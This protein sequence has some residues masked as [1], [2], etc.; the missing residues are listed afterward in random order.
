MLGA[1]ISAQEL[2][3]TA[4]VV[5]KLKVNVIVPFGASVCV[6]KGVIFWKVAP[7]GPP[8]TKE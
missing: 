8:D 5:V 6:A 7:V 2:L 3:L 1:E 4:M